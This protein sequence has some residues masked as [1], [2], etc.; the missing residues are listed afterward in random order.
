MNKAKAA[1]GLNTCFATSMP[2]AKPLFYMTEFSTP[3]KG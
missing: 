1:D 2:D 3:R